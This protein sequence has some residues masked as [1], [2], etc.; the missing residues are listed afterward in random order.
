M[1]LSK[2]PGVPT[3][4]RFSFESLCWNE[5]VQN[6]GYHVCIKSRCT[7]THS[8]FCSP[9]RL[10]MLFLYPLFCISNNRHAHIASQL[11]AAIIAVA[12][13]RAG[14]SCFCSLSTSV[15]CFQFCLQSMPPNC[16]TSAG[17]ECLAVQLFIATSSAHRWQACQ[18]RSARH[19]L[20][21]PQFLEG[22]R[23]F[24]L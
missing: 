6:N 17:Q 16:A 4:W 22:C 9:T 19:A 23:M 1:D 13:S 18:Q 20:P 8:T 21:V 3:C 15:S 14:M 12:S 24:F 2:K 10:P 7:T 5:S 11:Q